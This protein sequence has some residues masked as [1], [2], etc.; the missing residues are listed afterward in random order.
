MSLSEEHD[1]ND[2]LLRQSTSSVGAVTRFR[3]RHEGG[4]RL[5]RVG[6]GETGVGAVAMER[7]GAR[8]TGRMGTL[9]LRASGERGC[10]HFCKRYTHSQH[11]WVGRPTHIS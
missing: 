4:R 6:E 1:A 9:T 3:K 10:R 5:V 7:K 2:V 8:S 11:G